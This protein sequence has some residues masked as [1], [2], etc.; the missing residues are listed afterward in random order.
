MQSAESAQQPQPLGAPFVPDAR[1]AI[2]DHLLGQFRDLSAAILDGY[3]PTDT[4]GGALMA[5]LPNLLDELIQRRAAM[6]GIEL[7][8]K[9]GN[10]IAFERGR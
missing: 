9:P 8:C 7:L 2:T 3:H 10:V 6:A 4:E 1:A 5:C